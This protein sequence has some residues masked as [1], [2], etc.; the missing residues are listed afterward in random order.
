[1]NQKIPLYPADILL[2]NDGFEAW[3]V[4]ACDQFTSQPEYWQSLAA[5]IGDAPSTLNLILPEVYLEDHPEARTEAINQTMRAYLDAGIFNEYKNA[6]IYVE[7]TLKN[8]SIR[9]GIVAAVDLEAYDFTKGSSAPIRATEGTVLERIPPR[10]KIREGAPLELPHV[11]LLID[12]EAK[13]VIEPLADTA[14]TYPKLYDFTLSAGG[15][16]ICG[17]LLDE[18]AQECIMSA[19]A[20]LAEGENPLVFAVG[21]GNH[22]LATAKTCY[23][24]NG[25]NPLSR[26]ALVEIVNI[27]DSA[28]EF[29]PIYR[30]LFNCDP[31]DVTAYLKAHADDGE[32]S[33]KITCIAA[34]GE[35]TI[36]LSRTS[37]L[38]VGT[39]QHLIDDYIK[40]HPGVTVDYIHGIDVTRTL[41]SEPGRIGFLFEG[42]KKTELFETVR[43]DGALPR[44]TFSMGEAADKRYYLEARRISE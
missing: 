41:A 21:D 4:I 3:S 35:Q 14:D 7:R 9:R 25:K 28:L 15:G 13:A 37:N 39:L 19:L 16:S 26:Y 5:S 43:C 32:D 33:Q 10:V 44:K 1:M 31:T 6:M 2:P 23:E 29:E 11:M 8:G 30:V 40:A 34:D 18:S 27:H 20:P 24:Q 17:R 38:P 12:D 22:S 36:S 42:M